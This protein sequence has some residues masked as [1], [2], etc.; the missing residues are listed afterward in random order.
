[1]VAFF[2]GYTPACDKL[3]KVPP[4]TRLLSL[5][6]TTSVVG[7]LMIVACFQVFTFVYTSEQPWF[8]PYIMPVGDVPE[9]RRSMQGTAIF[10]VSMFQYITLAIIYSKGLPYR[11]PF[12]NNRPMCVSL[13]LLTL[14]SA[15]ITI[16]H[17]QF[18]VNWLEFDPIPYVEDRFFLLILALLSGICSYLFEA[19][20]IEYLLTDVRER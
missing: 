5:A 6:S 17:P 18:A 7:Q 1:L 16:V 13:V 3:Y 20:V 8:I 2:F 9:D 15:F 12:F 4:P 11:K 14:L 19:Y 10:C